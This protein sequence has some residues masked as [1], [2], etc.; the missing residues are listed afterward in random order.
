MDGW[1]PDLDLDGSS[2]ALSRSVGGQGVFSALAKPLP[3]GRYLY[4]RVVHAGYALYYVAA[5]TR[6]RETTTTDPRLRGVVREYVRTCM[7]CCITHLF[8]RPL[9]ILRSSLRRCRHVPRTNTIRI[10]SRRDRRPAG[11]CHGVVSPAFLLLSLH[12]S[13]GTVQHAHL[14]EPGGRQTMPTDLAMRGIAQSA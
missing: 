1:L 2:Q 14:Q 7:M 11:W 13:S 12:S 5:T 3:P 8:R 10:R 9:A 4:C 6:A